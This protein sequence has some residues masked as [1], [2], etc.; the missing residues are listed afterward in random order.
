MIEDLPEDPTEFTAEHLN[1]L[2]RDGGFS[3]SNPGA[4]ISEIISEPL[5]AE[6]AFL[7]SLARLHVTWKVNDT[8]LPDR[9][10]IKVPTQDPG[11]RRVGEMLNVWFRESEFY[12][13]L[14]PLISTP[15][16]ICR[17]NFVENNK[18]VLILDDLH[19]ASPGDQ[20]EGASA[21]QAHAAVEALAQLH[22]PFWT[23]SR[24]PSLS[25]V[26]GIDAPRLVDGLGQAMSQA[27]PRFVERFGEILPIEG[28]SWLHSFVPLLGGWQSNLMSNPITITHAD[29]RLAN[30]LFEKNGSIAVIDWQTAMFS[31]GATDLSF[32]LATNLNIATRRSLE[33]EL[34][35]AYVDTLVKLGIDRS[36]TQHIYEDYEQA[37][38]WWMGMLAN[39]L[40]TIETPDEESKRLFEAMLTRLYSA[41]LDANSGRFLGDY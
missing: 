6:S 5:A 1:Q 7:G 16:P 14:A 13:R 34:V 28:L 8:H 9:L 40:S 4:E 20:I 12:F 11:G 30:M 37:H 41:A 33:T 18:A 26:P 25:W 23:Q 39:N 19:P 15:V 38:L 31:G 27:L 35:H 29:Y 21:D 32:F 24:S 22:A 36:A 2:L 17:A 10:V 3:P